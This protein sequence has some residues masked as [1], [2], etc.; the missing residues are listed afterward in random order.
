MGREEGGKSERRAHAQRE[1]GEKERERSEQENV[2]VSVH[3]FP[4][5]ILSSTQENLHFKHS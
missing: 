3:F 4:Y 2:F 1:R 5:K